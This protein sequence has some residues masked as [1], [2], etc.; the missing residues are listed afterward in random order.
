VY[1][2]GGNDVYAANNSGSTVSVVAAPD[3]AITKT[4]PAA[5]AQ[6]LNGNYTITVSNVGTL[7]TSGTITVRDTLPAG[8][9]YVSGAGANWTISG[10][11]N[12][13][14]ATTTTAIAGGADAVFTVTVAPQAAAV[15]SVTNK[16]VV[17]GGNQF[18]LAN[19]TSIITTPVTAG[20]ID[21]ALAQSSAAFL[22]YAASSYSIIVTNNGTIASSGALTVTDTLPAGISFSSGSGSG[23]SFT[24]NGQVVVATFA[25]TIAAGANS[26]ITLNVDVGDAATS[27]VNRAYLTGGSDATS[28][29]NS[30][31]VTTAVTQRA[32]LT[33]TKTSSAP[34]LYGG[35]SETYTLAVQNIGSTASAGTFTITD[36]LPVGITYVSRTGTAW[37]VT[38]NATTRELIA[39][40]STAVAAGGVSQS[41]ILNVTVDANAFPSVTNTAWISGGAD[42]NTTNNSAS[43]TS[44]LIA[45]DLSISQTSPSNF[46]Q[47]AS[48]TYTITVT[49]AGAGATNGT[50]TVRDTLPTGMTYNSATGTNWTITGVNNVVVATRTTSIAASGTASFTVTVMPGAAAVPNVTNKAVVSGGNQLNQANDTSTLSTPVSGTTVFVDLTVGITSSSN[51]QQQFNSTYTITASNIGT[52]NSSGTIEVTDT[53]PTGTT[54]VSGSGSGWTFTTSGQVVTASRSTSIPLGGSSVLT[55]TVLVVPSA[56]SSVT[57]RAWISGGGEIVFNNNGSGNVVNGVVGTPAI[58]V[59]HAITPSGTVTPGTVLLASTQFSNTGN[60]NAVNVVVVAGVPASTDFQVNS[61]TSSMPAGVT[62]NVQYTVDGTVWTY[63]PVS[64]GCG[65]PAGFDRCVVKVRWLLQSPLAAGA[66]GS[67]YLSLR[68]R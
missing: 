31:T 4:S 38:W 25:G 6:G 20:T 57:N 52:A 11:N 54:F 64:G 42:G 13:V 61:V 2:S 9:S 12:V 48:G 22:E 8:M 65:A 16:A 63:T 36:T 1:L 59:L 40:N 56:P 39:T 66:S 58:S 32:D 43:T 37:T 47:G 23:W 18:N 33:L 67:A 29:N 28:G 10:T 51:F 14:V 27:I 34:F 17:S 49:N 26:A 62:A 3:L 50:I 5:F 60:A 68:V 53:L 15:P 19:D 41:L 7:A 55:I 46:T 30:A 45:P 24:A 35:A 44:A 21:L